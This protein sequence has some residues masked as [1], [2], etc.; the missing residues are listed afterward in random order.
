MREYVRA[1]DLIST[2][3]MCCVRV[4]IC[5]IGMCTHKHISQYMRL[6]RYYPIYN[7]YAEMFEH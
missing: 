5:G 3:H 2:A 6:E 7:S 4:S 1:Y